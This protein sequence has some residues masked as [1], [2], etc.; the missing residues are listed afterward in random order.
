MER[1]G[2]IFCAAGNSVVATPWQV[3]QNPRTVRPLWRQKRE[4][5]LFA[6]IRHIDGRQI[7]HCPSASPNGPHGNQQTGGPC[8]P[9]T[10]LRSKSRDAEAEPSSPLGCLRLDRKSGRLPLMHYRWKDRHQD[11]DR[12]R[13]FAMHSCGPSMSWCRYPTSICD[14]ICVLFRRA[15]DMIV[16]LRFDAHK[17]SSRA[18]AAISLSLTG[19]GWPA[20]AA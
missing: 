1:T 9:M 18:G 13:Q 17:G 6:Q 15:A 4:H 7:G 11:L 2:G 12:S 8:R 20:M 16:E 10:S 3:I 14:G 19:S 5:R